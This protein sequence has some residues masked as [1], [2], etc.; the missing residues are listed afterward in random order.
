Q[1][2]QAQAKDLSQ[3]PSGTY[4]TVILNSVVQYFPSLHY[5]QQVIEQAIECIGTTGRI[6][7]GDVRHYGLLDAFHLSVQLYQARPEVSLRDLAASVSHKVR[8]ESELLINPAWFY[9]L[10]ER[11]ARISQVQILPKEARYQNEMSA[12]RYDVV[13]LVGGEATLEPRVPWLDCQGCTPA[14]LKE[15]VAGAPQDVVGLRFVPNP[16]VHASVLGFSRL[17]DERLTTASDLRAWMADAPE[18]GMSCFELAEYCAQRGYAVRF[19]WVPNH[20]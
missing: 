11:C 18:V 7:L 14:T 19:S 6:F 8:T 4:D 20:T 10:K 3:L 13:L 2:L 1:L 5:L 9:M 15:L 12:Y 16:R 17:D